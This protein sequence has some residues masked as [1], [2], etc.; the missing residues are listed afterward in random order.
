MD[1]VTLNSDYQPEKL[2]ENYDSLI[3][4]ERFN[5]VGEFQIT[6]GD[7]ERFMNLL[8]EGQV[9]SLR[10]TNVPMIVETHKIERKKNSPTVLT[11]MGRE[12][13][14]ILDRRVSL[15]NLAGGSEEWTVVAKI[16]SDAAYYAIVTICVEGVLNPLD[17]FPTNK[18]VFAT[19]DDYLTTPGPIRQFTISRGNL[20]STVQTFLQTEDKEDPTTDPPTPKLEPHGIRAVRP[21][22]SGSAVTIQIYTG[23]DRTQEVYFDGTRDLLGDGTYLF[24]KVGSATT[25]YVLSGWNSH[26][27]NA[28]NEELSGFDRRVILVDGTTSGVTEEDALIQHGKSSLTEAKQI[29]IFDG[30]INQDLTLYV[31]GVDYGLGDIVKLVGDYGLS[32]KARVTEYIRSED[33]TG[34]KAYPTLETIL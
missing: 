15:K 9:V 5:G 14:S 21:N 26:V 27:I 11:I 28:K 34:V 4:T 31:F 8:P 25:A 19:P 1:L 30:S 24:S 18:V 23:I 7:V 2:V 17:I 22:I 12:F 6:T 33:A 10:E 20:L 16:P 29:A 3:W 32:E 13:T